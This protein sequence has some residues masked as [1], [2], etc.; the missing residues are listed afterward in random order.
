M[1]VFGVEQQPLRA[2]FIE[3]E[4]ALL[5]LAELQA[6]ANTAGGYAPIKWH[7]SDGRSPRSAP[8]H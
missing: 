2:Q 4:Y 1:L 3:K 7:S 5:N 6:M 8:G